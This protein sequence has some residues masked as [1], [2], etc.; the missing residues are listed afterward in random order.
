[1]KLFAPR[2]SAALAGKV[3]EALGIALAASEEREFDGG[4]HKMRPLEDVRGERTFVIHSLCGNDEGSA[5]DRLCRLLFF[6]GAL[7]DAGAS[8]VTAV[9]PYL[10]YAR[11]DRRTQPRDPVISRYVAAMFEAVG[12]DAVVV[13]DVHNEAALDNA[14]RIPTVRLEAAATFSAALAGRLGERSVVVAS[15]DVGGI[16]R[17]QRFREQLA[18]QL[19]RSIDFAFVEK[20]RAAGLVSGDA[21]VGSVADAEVVFYDDL[22]ASGTTL[23]RAVGAARRAGASRIHVAAPHAAFAPAAAQLFQPD[24]PETVLISDS[25]PLSGAFTPFLQGALQICSIAPLL[26]KTI[27][28]LA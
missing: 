8:R 1:M 14:F 24:G 13:L 28:D 21:L 18:N 16:K 17:A 26:A 9:V 5:N 10:A 20:R 2:L 22:I 19:G 4:E 23:L 27:A 6:A 7:R 11:K 15:P 12:V 3:A 25:I